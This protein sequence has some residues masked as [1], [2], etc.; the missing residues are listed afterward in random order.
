[1][2][3]A[4]TPPLLLRSRGPSEVWNA[5]VSQCG[6]PI[7]LA[8]KG[9]TATVELASPPSHPRVSALI[10]AD[11]LWAVVIFDS[12]PF[13][14][15]YK[16]N[17]E[18]DDLES[19][20]VGLRDVL[21]EGMLSTFWSQIP[22]N[23]L[24]AYTLKHIGD[25]REA[26]AETGAVLDWL[27]ISVNGLAP[28]PA[29]LRI[30]CAAVSVARAMI[31][32]DLS[33]R[34]VWSGIGGL[35]T[36]E[37]FFTLGRM[38]APLSQVRALAPDDLIVLPASED[39][40]S[41]LRLGRDLHQF[42]LIDEEWTYCGAQNLRAPRPGTPPTEEF[43]M[44]DDQTEWDGEAE[45]V[46]RQSEAE[47]AAP[48]SL[49]IDLDFDLGTAQVPLSTIESWQVGSVVEFNPPVPADGMEITLR[50]SG[51]AIATGDLVRIDE[52]LAV[53][54]TRLLLRP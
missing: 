38:P 22:Q 13:A 27:T 43:D 15:L 12:F 4:W 44:S 50:V 8:G 2:T 14:S 46:E 42:Q 23:R 1:M 25:W 26:V 51:Q 54:V 33:A 18:A 31:G 11:G 41:S 28:Q 32:G 9:V 45:E 24:P 30:G 47:E 49:M 7:A 3:L 10:E 6:A 39:G 20:P 19:L 36:S 34:A 29:R 16:A 17:L 53:R 48:P 5:L 35:L 21:I 37:G 40:A 52:R